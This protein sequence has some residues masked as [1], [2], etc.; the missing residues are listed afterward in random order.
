MWPTTKELPKKIDTG[1]FHENMSRKSKFGNDQTK[2]LGTL[3]EAQSTF[4]F[5]AG[6]I[7][8]PQDHCQATLSIFTLL[9][10]THNSTIHMERTAAFPP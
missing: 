1:N 3:H 7:N 2:I 5:V 6:D 4:S 10:V 8:L 9:T